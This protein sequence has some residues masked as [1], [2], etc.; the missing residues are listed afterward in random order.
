VFEKAKD[1]KMPYRYFDGICKQYQHKL[2]QTKL[3]GEP[4]ATP[5]PTPVFKAKLSVT[6]K[7]AALTT[8]EYVRLF[9]VE[10]EELTPVERQDLYAYRKQEAQDSGF[11]SELLEQIE[12]RIP[13]YSNKSPETRT[14]M[15]CGLQIP[16]SVLEDWANKLATDPNY[17]KRFINNPIATHAL[18][19]YL[20]RRAKQATTTPKQ[21][22]NLP[23][24]EI[25]RNVLG[26]TSN[27]DKY[28]D[29]GQI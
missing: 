10:W 1:V 7:L 2:E 11:W 13:A 5:K 14:E 24:K 16:E 23:D 28:F 12:A 4:K 3:T 22:S 26:G 25:S 8:E 27:Y 17:H 20:K 9:T 19:Q 18:E 6:E 21:V 15:P 29:S